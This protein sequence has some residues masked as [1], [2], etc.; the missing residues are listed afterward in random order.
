MLMLWL[1]KKSVYVELKKLVPNLI[2]IKCVCHSV[3]L[4]ISHSWKACMP[5]HLEFLVN[6]TYNWFSKSY[7]RQQSYKHIYEAINNEEVRI[8]R[9]INVL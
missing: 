4:A 3:Q 7:A 8:R 5:S 2:L 1:A 9:N 6:E